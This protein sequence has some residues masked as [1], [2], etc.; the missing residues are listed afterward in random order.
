MKEIIKSMDDVRYL[1]FPTTVDEVDLNL[2]QAR[3]FVRC[4][5]QIMDE[6][7]HP[8]KFA[9]ELMTEAFRRSHQK[10]NEAWRPVRVV[11][12]AKGHG[13]AVRNKF[14]KL[15]SDEMRVP[16]EHKKDF[17]QIL[18]EAG[19]RN[20]KKDKVAIIGIVDAALGQ[21]SD[22]EQSDVL[23]QAMTKLNL[24]LKKRKR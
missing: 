8:K 19:A 4:V 17:V 20:N 5:H 1:G 9:I 2:T 23:T 14:H 21:L 22:D 11:T 24:R 7:G 16:V 12:L 6:A 10:V 13:K 18:L 3:E 15:E